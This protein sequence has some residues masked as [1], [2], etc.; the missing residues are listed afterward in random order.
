MDQTLEFVLRIFMAGLMGGAIGFERGIRAKSAGIRTHFLVALGS[1]LLML[2]S[3]YAFEGA[4]QFDAARVAA[5]VVT[6]VGFLGAG[7]IIFQKNAVRGL[8]TAAG[9]WVA[10]AIGLAC[11]AGL[12][13][14]SFFTSVIVIACLE[15]MHMTLTRFEHKTVAVS[16]LADTPDIASDT[17]HSFG[18]HASNFN[19]FREGGKYKAVFE[20]TVDGTVTTDLIITALEQ[21]EG[22]T[23][24]SVE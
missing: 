4:R 16:F 7:V 10:S 8:T 18:K 11:G 3:Q 19:L 24:E 13:W 21:H 20:L 14:L 22:V 5:Q 9:I 2:V 15:V 17:V 6:G 23:I 12:Y 1:A